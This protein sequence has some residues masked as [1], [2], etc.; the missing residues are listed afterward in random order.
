MNTLK[1]CAK[2]R[3]IKLI[4]AFGTDRTH[5]DGLQSWCRQCKTDYARQTYATD[6]G[7]AAHK[8]A[9]KKWYQTHRKRVKHCPH[10]GKTI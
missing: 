2:C 8:K 3:Q 5:K 4:T 1:V 6:K 9:H 7:K 10:C